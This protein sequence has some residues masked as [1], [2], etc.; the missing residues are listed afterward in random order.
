MFENIY[1]EKKYKLLLAV[2][3]RER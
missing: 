2:T 3:H 1:L